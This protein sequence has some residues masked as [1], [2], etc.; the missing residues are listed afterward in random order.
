MAA[1]SDH[2]SDSSTQTEEKRHN[3]SDSGEPENHESPDGEG[4]EE[5]KDEGSKEDKKPKAPS[6]KT[7]IIGGIV[8]GILLLGGL[9][10]YLHSRHF[11]STDDAYTAGHVHQ[12]GARVAGTVEKVL[13]DDNARVK[14]GQTLVV[15]DPRVYEVAL[16]KARAQSGQA[17]AWVRSSRA[18]VLQKKAASEQAKA[19]LDKA[20]IDYDRASALY[21]KDI[22][23]VSKAEVDTATAALKG[24]Q[25]AYAAAKANT[26]AAEAQLGV[27]MAG[28]TTAESEVRDAELQLSYTKVI[29]PVNGMVSKKTVEA[30]QRIQPGQALMAVVEDGIWV[31]A[32]LKETQ[33]ARVRVGQKVDISIDAVPDKTFIGHVDS[34]QAGTGAEFALLPPDNATGN[35]TKIVQRVPVK[36]VFEPDSI[37]GYRDRIVP[38][39]SA[40]PKIDLRT[41]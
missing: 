18:D 7:L 29:A 10:Y 8:L 39:L 9:L 21:G 38:G 41:E 4:S 11:E 20:Q 25:G 31:V 36:I 1:R 22:R 3:R 6:K 16:A 5:E 26:A 32:N 30:G 35:F 14:A 37:R 12:I 34:F 33:L 2:D 27:N 23:A 19:N 24:A 15:L 40:E 17:R 28:I 13:V